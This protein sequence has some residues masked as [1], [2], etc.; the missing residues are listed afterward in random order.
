M[1]GSLRWAMSSGRFAA[2]SSNQNQTDEVDFGAL[3]VP[4]TTGVQTFIAFGMAPRQ[5]VAIQLGS[6]D[7]YGDGTAQ[8]A[9]SDATRSAG[10]WPGMPLGIIANIE[11]ASF[12]LATGAFKAY[13]STLTLQVALVSASDGNTPGVVNNLLTAALALNTIAFPWTQ[14]SLTSVPAAR[15][16]LRPD[17]GAVIANAFAYYAGDVL[18]FKFANTAGAPVTVAQGDVLGASWELI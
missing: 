12:T 8:L 13:A 16:V 3:N 18:V 14:L 10:I 2:R 6:P 17:T 4:A 15:Q 11:L 9:A 5:T 1:P 7:A